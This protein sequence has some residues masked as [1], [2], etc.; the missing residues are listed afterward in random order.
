MGFKKWFINRIVSDETKREWEEYNERVVGDNQDEGKKLFESNTKFLHNMLQE[1]LNLLYSSSGS[2]HWSPNKE[3]EI[4]RILGTIWQLYIILSTEGNYCIPFDGKIYENRNNRLYP[5]E[6]P[7]K[8]EPF[9]FISVGLG[10]LDQVQ[11]VLREKQTAAGEK[12]LEGITFKIKN[13][14]NCYY[15]ELDGKLYDRRSGKDLGIFSIPIGFYYSHLSKMVFDL[16][17]EFIKI[18]GLKKKESLEILNL[19]KDLSNYIE[20]NFLSKKLKRELQYP[21]NVKSKKELK[22]KYDICIKELEKI[23]NKIKE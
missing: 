21:A 2:A 10:P 12:Q 1:K 14:G 22:K 18:S 9:R 7:V 13:A 23:E 4:K 15:S 17:K 6:Y 16:K 3:E 19:Q 11:V 5:L 20:Y 8:I